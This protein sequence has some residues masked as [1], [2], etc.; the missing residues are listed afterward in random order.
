MQKFRP[1]NAGISLLEMLV[2]L[3][4]LSLLLLGATR[5]FK[6]P[7]PS[8]QA[9]SIAS[10]LIEEGGIARQTAIRNRVLVVLDPQRP[11]TDCRGNDAPPIQFFS[12]GSLLSRK[13][14]IE[15]DNT[16]FPLSTD[17]LT[18]RIGFE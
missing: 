10:T 14:C 3:A 1:S 11:V 2:A 12:D 9:K 4:L 18:G 17:A 5:A 6:T 7:S 16:V 8:L 13:L 15:I